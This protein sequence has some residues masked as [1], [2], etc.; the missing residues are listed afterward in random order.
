MSVKPAGRR[1][2][3]RRN[4]IA[5]DID[6]ITQL[7]TA[8][9]FFACHFGAIGESTIK[10][11]IHFLPPILFALFAFFAVKVNP[12]FARGL[13]ARL[14]TFRVGGSLQVQLAFH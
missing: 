13:R 1:L 11:A 2:S 4:E 6:D 10:A 7:D 5:F 9:R 14:R 8:P 12:R 3:G